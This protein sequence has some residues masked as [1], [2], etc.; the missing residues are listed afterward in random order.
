VGDRES[1]ASPGAQL[2]P[3]PERWAQVKSIFSSAVELAPEDRPDFV[4]HACGGD[5]SLKLEV[6]SLLE[7]GAGSTMFPKLRAAVEN[8]AGTI[9]VAR[10]DSISELLAIALGDQ[11]EIIREL[12]RGG[13]GA[14][15]LA[16]EKALERLVAI[17]VLRPELAASSEIRER[18]RREARIAANLS[19]PGILQLHTFG[20]VSGVWYFVM[21]YVRGESLAE[22]LRR[23][24]RLP[25]TE[26]HRILVELSDAL[27]CA[28][29]YHVVHRDIKPANILI[30]AET[31]RAV[32]ADFGISKIFG[33]DDALTGTGVVIGT[34]DYMSPEQTMGQSDVDER[35]DIYSLG[36]VGYTMLCGRGP[37]AGEN[38]TQLMY[39][40]LMRDPTPIAEL[41]P[42]VP[43]DFA[44]AVMKCL[45]RDRADRWDT[46]TSLRQTLSVI[47]EKA[48]DGLPEGIRDIPSFGPYALAWFFGWIAV[49]M[50]SDRATIE[51]ALLFIVACLVPIGLILHVWMMGGKGIGLRKLARV[52]LRPPEW[53]SMYWPRTFRRP[54][55]LWTRLPLPARLFRIVSSGFFLALAGVLLLREFPAFDNSSSVASRLTAIEAFAVLT[56]VITVLS[57]LAWARNRKLSTEETVRLLLGPTADSTGWNT[58]RLMRL[59]APVTGRIRP[60]DTGDAADFARAIRELA[61]ILPSDLAHFRL[62]ALDLADRSVETL[63]RQKD[64]LAAMERDAGHTEAERLQARIAALG[65]VT[66]TEPKQR[67]EM[68][69]VLQR[70][71]GLVWQMRDRIELV[72]RQR[73]RRFELLASLYSLLCDSCYDEHE[74]ST[75]SDNPAKLLSICTELRSELELASA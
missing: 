60:P 33:A 27:A 48:V 58:P 35:S 49:A 41:N 37:F 62:T 32:L 34:P 75:T 23:R 64:D 16:R 9:H 53:W 12:G 63:D 22:L 3:A 65:E 29:R 4:N 30:E 61:A 19:H 71:L 74:S 14:V 25:W 72:L 24:N 73:S 28:H 31:G 50:L 26:T 54:S 36:A 59:L 52:A 10:R 45:A 5:E 40:R 51:R 43:E 20:E 21:S 11:Y 1:V 70:E 6:E 68:R 46:A 7:A 55:D 2:N 69:L 8:E 44:A 67:A 13:M 42:T 57:G 38:A 18:F 56:L 47:G 15:Y 17:K 39:S 66:P